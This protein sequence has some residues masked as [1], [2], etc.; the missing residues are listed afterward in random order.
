MHNQ[1]GFVGTATMLAVGTHRRG[2]VIAGAVVMAGRV[3][4]LQLPCGRVVSGNSPRHEASMVSQTG[5]QHHT[6]RTGLCTGSAEIWGWV[7]EAREAF[8]LAKS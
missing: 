2:L 8:G 6:C 4:L 1:T 7:G 5:T 3:R